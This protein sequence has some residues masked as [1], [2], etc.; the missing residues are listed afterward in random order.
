MGTVNRGG[1]AGA[2]FSFVRGTGGTNLDTTYAV[3][4]LTVDTTNAPKS[5]IFPG[6][7]TTSST[8]LNIGDTTMLDSMVFEL[9]SIAGGAGTLFFYLC[10]DAAGDRPITPEASQS[11]LT[12]ATT[13]TRGGC[14]FT[15]DKMHIH[16]NVA[17]VDVADTLHVAVRVDVGT[18]DCDMRLYWR[19]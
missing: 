18:A 14:S 16:E 15:I 7:T 6:G 12:G 17:T 19:R 10:R 11:I 9:S 5:S 13:A 8:V 3:Y 4:A 1:W 2:G